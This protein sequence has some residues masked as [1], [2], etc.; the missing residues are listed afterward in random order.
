M[1]R[2]TS[3]TSVPKHAKHGSVVDQLL[4]HAATAHTLYWG[5][6][7][8]ILG[9]AAPPVAARHSPP[10]TQAVFLPDGGEAARW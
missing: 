10:G 8:D 5:Q 9:C 3:I 2:P 1:Q 4:L 7:S 6:R